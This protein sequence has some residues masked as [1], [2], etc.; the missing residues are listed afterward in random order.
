MHHYAAEAMTTAITV[1][2]V[3]NINIYSSEELEVFLV[4]NIK[5][6]LEVYLHA[7]I[8]KSPHVIAIL[9]HD[10]LFVANI[11]IFVHHNFRTKTEL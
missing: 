9:L 1:P 3:V 4:F 2:E 8:V 5:S 11:H 6:I 7:V 10:G